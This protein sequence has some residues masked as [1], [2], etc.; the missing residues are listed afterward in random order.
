MEPVYR[1]RVA[2]KYR[3]KLWRRIDVKGSQ[4]LGDLDCIIREV[5]KHYVWDHLS[6]FFRGRVWQS[7]VLGEVYPDG[8]GSGAE[9]RIDGLGLSERDKLEYVYDFGDDIQHIVTLEKIMEVEENVK[10]PRVVSRNKPK[11]SYC[12]VCEKL[13]KRTIA[14]WIC[15]ECSNEAQQEV[16]VCEDCLMKEHEDHYAEEALY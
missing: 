3:R 2:L 14:T 5:F 9:K 1:F 12:E 11:Y 7:E 16:L 13:G 6:E 4:T 15:I 8:A 10:Y